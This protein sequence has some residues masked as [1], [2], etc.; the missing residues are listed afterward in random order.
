M[1]ALEWTSHLGERFNSN[2]VKALEAELEDQ[3]KKMREKEADLEAAFKVNSDLHA[4][5]S[6]FK[7]RIADLQKEVEDDKNEYLAQYAK[8]QEAL[9]AERKKNEKMFNTGC[10]RGVEIFRTSGQ[11]GAIMFKLLQ[12]TIRSGFADAVNKISAL[13]PELDLSDLEGYDPNADVEMKAKLIEFGLEEASDAEDEEEGSELG[14]EELVI[15]DGKESAL[16]NQQTDARVGQTERVEGA[17]EGELVENAL[18]LQQ[19]HPV[20]QSSEAPTEEEEPIKID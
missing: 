18:P 14:G 9:K 12:P 8:F 17:E 20:V 4:E 19:V 15:K 16:S 5:V 7:G 11:M 1:Q 13:H 2:K 10:D 3:K 6:S